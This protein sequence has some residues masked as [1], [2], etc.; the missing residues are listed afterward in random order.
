MNI[1]EVLTENAI[2]I[3]NKIAVIERKS[4]TFLELENL[5]NS[6]ANGFKSL[7]VKSGDKVLVFIK[8]SLDFPAVTF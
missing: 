4:L 3:P 7:G 6:Y 5:S 1:S 2:K 8:P